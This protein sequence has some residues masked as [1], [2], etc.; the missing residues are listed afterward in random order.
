MPVEYE[1][2]SFAALDETFA[3]RD[4]MNVSGELCA[5]TSCSRQL[6]PVDFN[7]GMILDES[8][9]IDTTIYLCVICFVTYQEA[10]RRGVENVR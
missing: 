8:A 1:G 9:C 5:T 3:Q 7:I 2:W 10:T 4:R 6:S